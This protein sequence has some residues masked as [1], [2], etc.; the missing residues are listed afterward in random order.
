MAHVVDAARAKFE[1]ALMAAPTIR[2]TSLAEYVEDY[3]A[4]DNEELARMPGTPS[5]VMAAQ[6]VLHAKL[7]NNLVEQEA[8]DT[9][10]FDR[11]I[12]VILRCPSARS[13]RR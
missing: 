6:F 4:R 9:A 13:R 2:M 12:D 3:I 11:V 8:G 5:Q 7:A 1:N 10:L